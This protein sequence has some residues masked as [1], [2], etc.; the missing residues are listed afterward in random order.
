VVLSSRKFQ[1]YIQISARSLI[2]SLDVSDCLADRSLRVALFHS[3]RL[4][5]ALSLSVNQWS[6]GALLSSQSLAGICRLLLLVACATHAMGE[7]NI[8]A[9]DN[10][11][12]DS[13]LQAQ[14]ATRSKIRSAVTPVVG[15]IPADRMTTWNPGLNAVGG[16]PNRA[17]IYRT[18]SPRGGSLDDTEQIQSALNTCPR[19]QVVKLNPGTFNINRGGL[20][21]RRS[22]CTLRGAGTGALGS[23]NGGTRL[24][25]TDR[26]T[27]VSFAVLY[28][29]Y[30]IDFASSINLTADAI[31]GT[32]SLSLVNNPS[33]SVGEIVLID[34]ATDN[35]P[36]VW[37]GPEHNPPG[38]SSRRWFARQDRSLSQMME[39]TAVSGNTVTFSTPFHITFKTRYGAQ[40]TRYASPI[41]HR[42]GIEDLYVYGGMGGDGHGNVAVALCAYCWVKNIE[43]HW[44]IG[45]SVGFYGTFRSVL[46]DSYIHETPDPNPGGGGY[47]VGLNSGASDNLIENNVMWSGNKNI[48][49]RATGGGNVIAYNY[50]DDAF[51]SY[52][53][54]MPEAGLNA[55]HYTTPHMELLEGNYSHNYKGDS[56]WGNSIYITVFRN[57]LSGLR[58]ARPPLDAY[59]HDVYPYMDLQGRTAVDIQAHSDYTNLVGNVLGSRGEPLLSYNQG[60]YSYAQTAWSYERLGGFPKNGEVTMWSIG[61]QQAGGWTW[62]PTTYLTQLR[63]GNWDWVSRSQRWH[64]I[65]GPVGSGTPQAIPDSLYIAAKP[66]FFGLNPWP[67]VIPSSG[68]VST[69]PAKACFEQGK[70]PTCM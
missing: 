55:G 38:G 31:K 49:M 5:Y 65:G 20:H 19:D 18:L 36:R 33:I 27:N 70:M 52:Y 14:D 68:A 37:W 21:F 40:L 57:H 25:K 22:D 29:G 44:S 54:N 50:M 43:A 59:K 23:G 66:A 2:A 39:V 10:P 3:G 42:V 34:Q 28:V 17:T 12:Y 26:D 46:R 24:I 16:I 1:P 53:P 62:V 60:G 7:T 47:L 67:W 61:S 56:F 41:L 63:E 35:D 58:A 30:G 9:G 11:G 32:N 64:G 15:I 51:G 48:V 4:L 69:L 45:T 13:H 8:H 6:L